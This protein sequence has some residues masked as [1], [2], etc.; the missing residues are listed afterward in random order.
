MGHAGLLRSYS[1][2]RR[3][4]PTCSQL[5]AMRLLDAK[6]ASFHVAGE[7][8]NSGPR[9]LARRLAPIHYAAPSRPLGRAPLESPAGVFLLC[10]AWRST[11]A[12]PPADDNCRP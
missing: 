5:S 10:P 7:A 3:R 11:L 4:P 2:G 9:S 6:L 12:A 8:H 1:S